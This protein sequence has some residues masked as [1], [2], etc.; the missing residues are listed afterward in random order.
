MLHWF[1]EAQV[2]IRQVIQVLMLL[3]TILLIT[4]EITNNSNASI[5]NDNIVTTRSGRVVK[6]PKKYD[7]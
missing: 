1:K 4:S 2:I 7:T 3:M 5:V 6:R